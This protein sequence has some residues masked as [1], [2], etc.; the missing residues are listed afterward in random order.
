MNDKERNALKQ[1]L[2]YC[3][4]TEDVRARF[5]P[6]RKQF[7]EEELYRDGCAFYIQQMGEFVNDLSD[8]FI[9][10]HDDI[11][12]HEIRGFRNII[13]HAYASVD[14]D[15]LWE[16]ITEDLPPLRKFCERQL[17]NQK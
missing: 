17:E 1:I 8:E 12:W 13:A 3:R 7:D 6:T 15:I 14:T 4:K 11:A 5:F 10:Q 2:R 9:E 16:S